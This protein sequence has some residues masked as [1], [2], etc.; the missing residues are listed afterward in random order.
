MLTRKRV[1]REVDYNNGW[2][3][4]VLTYGIEGIEKDLL[5]DTIQLHI[6]DTADTEEEFQQRFPVGTTLCILTTT[7]ITVLGRTAV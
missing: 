3:A 5:L 2:F 7:E 4:E 1:E 6:E